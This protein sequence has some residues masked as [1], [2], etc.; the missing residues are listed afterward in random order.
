MR[1]LQ[2]NK[3]LK[4]VGGAE[5]YMFQLSKNLQ[6]LGHEVKFWGMK[7]TD[8]LF[9][10]FP[11]LEVENIDYSQQNLTK[12]LSSVTTTIYSRRNRKK[13]AQVLDSFQPDIVHLHNYNFQVTPSILPEIYKRGIKVVQTVH[14]SQMVCPY[15]RIYNFQRDTVCTKC[16]T[17]SFSNCIKDRC[18]DGSILKS[19]IGAVE[20]TLYH[21][22]KYYEKY[23][24]VYISPSNFLV[25]LLSE[26]I[27]KN[28]E[29]IP[30]FTEVT[31]SKEIDKKDYYLYYGRISEEKGI[32]EMIDIFEKASIPLLIIGKGA[33]ENKVKDKIKD[34]QN[35]QFLGPKYGD[36]L[37][38]YVQ[39]SKYVVQIAKGYE[40]CPMTVIESF[41]LNVPVIASNH[42]G[43]KD[44]IT[45]QKTGYLLD[46]TDKSNAIS[47]L[48]EIDKR[49]ISDVVVNIKNF[50]SKKL[51]KEIHLDKIIQIYNKLISQN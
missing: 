7:D 51:S 8:N 43:F 22:L 9:C 17:G 20:S 19:T 12:K 46:F 35:I 41:A 45:D 3:Y 4:I 10:D 32:L 30:N 47:K 24:D 42:S 50:Y 29:V 33:N 23:I 34:I 21:S 28:I 25:S 27:H 5:T 39:N 49:D 13:I 26:R 16:V 40:N 31:P 1:I 37:F 48:I 6:A 38:Q 44:L 36:E 2:I 15:H 14:D 18:F 11:N